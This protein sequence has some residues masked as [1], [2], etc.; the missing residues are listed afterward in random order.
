M[1]ICVEFNNVITHYIEIYK[2]PDDGHESAELFNIKEEPNESEEYYCICLNPP[3][4][5]PVLKHYVSHKMVETT[6]VEGEKDEV[7]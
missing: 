2:E 7:K 1:K 4:Y 5:K 3:T 6:K